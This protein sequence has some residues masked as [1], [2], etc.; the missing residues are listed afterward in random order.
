MSIILVMLLITP[1]KYYSQNNSHINSHLKQLNLTNVRIIKCILNRH[2]SFFILL[3]RQF[4]RFF[5]LLFLVSF[6]Q[7]TFFLINVNDL[8]FLFEGVFLHF[9]CKKILHA[10]LIISFFFFG[11]LKIV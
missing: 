4:I 1:T 2:E 8:F 11:N 7:H 10:N 5:F 3:Q 6:L 9:F